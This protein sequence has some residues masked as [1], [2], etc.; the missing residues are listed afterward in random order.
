[1]KNNIDIYLFHRGEHRKTYDFLG[2]HYSEEKTIFRTWAPN[3]KKIELVGDFNNWIGVPM[4]KI[5]NEGIWEVEVKNVRK[6]DRYKYK[7]ESEKGLVQYKSDPY[8][9]YSEK[10]PNTASVVYKI[11]DF[12]WKDKKWMGKKHFSKDKPL[13]IYEVHLGSWKQKENREFLNYKELAKELVKYVKSMN[14][15]CVE[16]LPINEHPLDDS[17]GYQGTG[18]FSTTSRYGTPEDFMYFVNYLH[19]NEIGVILDWVPGHFCKD[20]HGLYLF[21]GTPTYEYSWDLLRENHEWGTANFDF[22]RNEVRSF[23]ISNALYWL[24]EFHIDGLRVDAVANI[25]YLDYGKKSHPNL[26]N[27]YGENINLSGINF[28]RELNRV[29]K[30]EVPR[31]ITIAEESTAW[32]G[33]TKLENENGLGFDYKW[34]MGWMNDTLSYIK[35]DPIFRGGNHKKLTFPMLYAYS[36]NY[37]LPFSHDE[38]V[39][40]KKSLINKIPGTLEEKLGNLKALYGY[41]ITQ[42]G[43]KLQFMGNE[44]AHYL[45]WRFYEELEWKITKEA[46]GKYIKRFVK[47]LNKIYLKE[48]ALWEKDSSWD[49]FQWIDGNNESTSVISYYRKGKKIEDDLIIIINF[50]GVN[51][52]KYRIG[53]NKKIKYKEILNSNKNIYGG[54][55]EGNK[56]IYFSEKVGWHGFHY[57]IELMIPA[58]SVFI[59]KGEY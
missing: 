34:N 58:F 47:D 44:F 27:E 11:E 1:M 49:G 48:K 23:L 52:E 18:F 45:E 24:K 22:S 35:E 33:V 9:I 42:P 54:H 31:A 13:N 46:P 39:H 15:N 10:R 57:S 25:I 3:A 19:C 53:V 59:L 37:I 26:K 32:Y 56:N 17:W 55:D 43:K 50:S 51:W 40:G 6:L 29:I 16:I 21:D 7:I 36:E 38:V 14:Y 5:N 20:E 41:M 4:V 12:L 8:G 30:K 2:V 28:L